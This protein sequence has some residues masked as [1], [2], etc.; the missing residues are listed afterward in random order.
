VLGILAAAARL[1]P[2]PFVDDL[3][4][5]RIT[6]IMIRQT[7][8]A[9]GRTYSTALVSPLWSPPFGCASGCLLFLLKLPIVLI[10]YPFRKI[11]A[12]VTAIRGLAR[13]LTEMILLGRAVDRVLSRG[14]LREAE[15]QADITAEAAR[16]RTAFENAAS[17]M[18]LTVLKAALAAALGKVSGMARAALRALRS[19]W[20]KRVSGE[21]ERV[22]LDAS[23]QGV[24]D[25]GARAVELALEKP[26]VAK[27]LAR[28]DV[29]FD[30]NLAILRTRR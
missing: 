16:V 20:R 29:T 17:G 30:E 5:E 1:V 18:D 4:R 21:E 25:E 6:Q 24:L 28:F 19:L 23:E 3:L 26:E 9:H 12:W 8:R 11:W 13:D 15:R 14:E 7:L 10:T 27:L 22:T 2:V